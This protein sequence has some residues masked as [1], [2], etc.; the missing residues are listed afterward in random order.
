MSK[1]ELV[2]PDGKVRRKPIALVRHAWAEAQKSTKGCKR[3]C[4]GGPHKVVMWWIAG[5]MA[6]AARA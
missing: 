2:C 5:A 6:R 3:G 1:W 4:P